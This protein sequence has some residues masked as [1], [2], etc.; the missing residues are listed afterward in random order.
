MDW[1]RVDFDWNHV[2]AFLVTADEGSFSAAARTL[3][4]AQPTVGR[5]VAAL[6]EELGV[7]LFERVGR[8]LA[9]TPTGVELAEHVRAMAEAAFR[10]SRVAAGQAVALDGPISISASEVV[11][12]YLLPPLVAAL[13]AQ[14]PGIDVEIVASNAPQ[15]LR[16]READI[17]IRNFRP[18]EPDLV[19]RKIRDAE[20][21]LYAT[22][23]YLRSLG[24]PLDRDA[25][26]RAA[27]IGFDRADTFRAGLAAALGLSLTPESFPIVCASQHVQWALVRESA[28]IGIM[29]AEIG[30]AEP[31]VRRVSKDL[32]PIPIPMWLVT[33]RDVRTSR[34]V[35][36]VAD[37]LAQSLVRPYGKARRARPRP[38]A[39]R[40]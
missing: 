7:T 37:I 20:A 9:L 34:R 40:G 12:T 14:H 25:L 32:P 28:G 5:Q 4:M 11:A 15:D 23:K 2:R 10:V 8:G 3:R 24:K 33:H 17:A 30:D 29:M 22:P 16:R 26:S 36:V 27:F 31:S 18:S 35:R 39:T 21:Y 38:K 1:R 13:R 19:A 6:E